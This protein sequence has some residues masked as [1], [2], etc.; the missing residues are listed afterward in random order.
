MIENEAP[1]RRT[2]ADQKDYCLIYKP[3]KK[4]EVER[5]TVSPTGY[6]NRY[7]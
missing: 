7:E 3:P 4:A 2:T 1:D 6:P 5:G